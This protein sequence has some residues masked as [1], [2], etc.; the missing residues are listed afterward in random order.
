[1]GYNKFTSMELL[2]IQEQIE[3]LRIRLKVIHE[4]TFY[5]SD[6]ELN[7]RIE[8]C[9]KLNSADFWLKDL[10]EDITKQHENKIQNTKRPQ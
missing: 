10:S 1:L 2:D 4:N 6:S 3:Q 7:Q 8:N 9:T 5:C